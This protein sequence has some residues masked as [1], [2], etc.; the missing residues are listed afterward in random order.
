MLVEG[1]NSF[2][3]FKS[4]GVLQE[5]EIVEAIFMFFETELFDFT[6]FL[7]ESFDLVFN[8]LLCVFSVKVGEEDLVTVRVFASPW[9][10]L[11]A[12]GRAFLAF[13]RH[14]FGC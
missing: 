3:G 6:V 1:F 2:I 10:F 9:L 12:G 5:A 13:Y 11:L 14:R 4:R 8:L 7:K